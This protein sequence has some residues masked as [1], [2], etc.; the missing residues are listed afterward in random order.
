[1]AFSS[2]YYPLYL[3]KKRKLKPHNSLSTSSLSR[4]DHLSKKRFSIVKAINEIISEYNSF[5]KFMIYLVKE[6]SAENLLW[7]IEL[8]QIKYEYQINNNN[9]IQLPKDTIQLKSLIKEETIV[10]EENDTPSLKPTTSSVK[11]KDNSLYQVVDFNIKP[12]DNIGDK[13]YTYLFHNNGSIMTPIY[14]SPKI[15]QTIIISENKNNLFLQ[16]KHLYNKYIKISS[17]N[18]LNISYEVR[19]SLINYFENV[20]EDRDYKV[21]NIMDEVAVEVLQLLQDSFRRFRLTDEFI[22]I[23]KHEKNEKNKQGNDQNK[24]TE[25]AMKELLNSKKI[26]VLRNATSYSV[27]KEKYSIS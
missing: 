10:N 12:L 26:P 15:P 2:S 22:Q 7:L 19:S 25:L 17:D 9:L 11:K 5:Q 24:P 6:F 8:V 4:Q 27:L 23:Q 13:L 21:F 1:M 14:L 3:I 18:E 16:M 20:N